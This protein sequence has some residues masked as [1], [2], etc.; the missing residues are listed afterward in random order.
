MRGKVAS[1][2]VRQSAK[3]WK[4]LNTWPVKWPIL[5]LA[6]L[7]GAMSN[8]YHWGRAPVAAAAAVILPI[9]GFRNYWNEVRFWITVLLLG[10]I[11]V[12]IV[13]LINPIMEEVKFPFL[14]AFGVLDC[15]L[16]ALAIFW[17]CSKV[18][19]GN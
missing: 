7:F 9:I 6:V 18:D 19:E 12:P 13:L 1:R 5:A 8:V 2:D 16:V 17:I 4:E 15:V 10:A 14:F 3:K 11:Q